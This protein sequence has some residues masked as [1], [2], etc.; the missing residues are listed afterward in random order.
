MHKHHR[1]MYDTGWTSVYVCISWFSGFVLM[2]M[3]TPQLWPMWAFGGLIA[4]LFIGLAISDC[5]YERI[6]HA[7]SQR[8]RHASRTNRSGS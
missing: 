1:P 7:R 3:L 4:L 8:H 2:A 6:L 5:I